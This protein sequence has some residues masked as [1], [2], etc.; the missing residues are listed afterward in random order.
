MSVCIRKVLRPAILTQVSLASL[1]L[2]AKVEMVPSFYCLLLIQ[3]SEVKFITMEHICCKG[4]L[5]SLQKLFSSPLI[6]KLKFA[7]SRSQACNNHNSI[8]LRLSL[9]EG[10]TGEYWE[11]S[12]EMK[13]LLHSKVKCVSLLPWLLPS[14]YS[15]YIVSVPLLKSPM[16]EVLSGHESLWV[17]I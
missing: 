6:Q 12:N 14:E 11:P 5:N 2:Q 3:P 16:G 17:L 4:P 9:S 8:I 10:R 1:R 15:S 13:F 7:R